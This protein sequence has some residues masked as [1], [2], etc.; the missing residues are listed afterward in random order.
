MILNDI[1]EYDIYTGIN[2]DQTAN[3]EIIFNILGDTLF[4]CFSKLP[5]IAYSAQRAWILNAS[6]Q[7]NITLGDDL[8]SDR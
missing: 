2:N 3:M 7:K 4:F 6:L 5:Q 1:Y 8:K